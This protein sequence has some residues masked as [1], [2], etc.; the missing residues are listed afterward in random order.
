MNVSRVTF[1]LRFFAL[2]LL[3]V[4]IF[5][6]QQ[7]VT[8][9]PSNKMSAKKKAELRKLS[10]SG[11]AAAKYVLSVA[12]DSVEESRKLIKEASDLNYAPAMVSYAESYAEN[13]PTKKR[14]LLEKASQQGYEPGLVALV[15]CIES[16]ACGADADI[17][18]FK[19]SLLLEIWHQQGQIKN[20]RAAEERKKIAARLSEAQQQMARQDSL[21][22]SKSIKPYER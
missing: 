3:C 7:S 16:K 21:V 12:V 9:V 22:L 19:W 8:P 14:G 6:C 20:D 13:Q 18:G 5:G 1:F 4:P 11:D 10:D 17:A 15:S 2:L